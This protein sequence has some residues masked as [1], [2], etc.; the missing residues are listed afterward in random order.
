MLVGHRTN[1]VAKRLKNLTS[2]AT[3]LGTTLNDT[4][5]PVNSTLYLHEALGKVIEETATQT[6]TADP[7]FGGS[8]YFR[9]LD[10]NLIDG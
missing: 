2:L 1:E 4:P 9:W 10:N 7:V 3:S 5:H 6:H 8:L